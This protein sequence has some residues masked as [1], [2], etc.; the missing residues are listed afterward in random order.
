[1]RRCPVVFRSGKYKGSVCGTKLKEDKPK[2]SRHANVKD[3]DPIVAPVAPVA[4][5]V[6]DVVAPPA[7]VEVPAP[8]AKVKT[9]KA[10]KV[11]KRKTIA[12]VASP[13]SEIDRINQAIAKDVMNLAGFN[14]PY[15]PN[16]YDKSNYSKYVMNK[17]RKKL[18]TRMK[19][20]LTD[21]E[22]NNMT[23]TDAK[24]M[25]SQGANE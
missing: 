18:S 19:R 13:S 23:L 2:C 14:I 6:P 4:E 20:T 7:P 16:H 21:E 25:M 1:M 11:P 10:P 17:M 22:F 8:V 15:D 3:Y 9:V 5:A 24:V 12:S